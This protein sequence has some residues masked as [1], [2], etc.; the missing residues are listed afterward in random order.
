[1]P[2]RAGAR[3]AA[4]PWSRIGGEGGQLAASPAERLALAAGLRAWP[5]QPVVVAG[6]LY[7]V[8][9]VR[10]MLLRERSD[11]MTELRWGERTYVMGIIN[12]TPDSFS[13]DGLAPPGAVGRRRGGRG[14]GQA[15]GFV[16]AG[17]DILDV[18]AE[19]TRPAQFYGDHP[20]P[21]PDAEAAV[22]VPVV[23]ALA[24]RGAGRL[25]SIDTSRGSV[26]RAA[27]A[28]GAEIVNDVWGGRADPDTVRAAAE[29]GAYLVLM[30]NR[31][32]AEPTGRSSTTWSPGCVPRSRTPSPAAWRSTG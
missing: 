1:M 24:R 22:A 2:R 11:R 31:E 25:I 16:A 20:R 14:P 32:R 8:G 13:G 9:A 26:A 3:S 4:A 18:G 27:L 10:G 17:A 5:D 30:H 28:A 6:S 21:T 19:S 15:R 12:V 7:L 23:R 29:A